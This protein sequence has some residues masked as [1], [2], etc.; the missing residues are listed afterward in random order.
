[1]LHAV[2]QL[3]V[4]LQDANAFAGLVQ[5]SGELGS[6]EFSIARSTDLLG[7]LVEDDAIHSAQSR[8]LALT[9]RQPHNAFLDSAQFRESSAGQCEAVLQMNKGR[10]GELC[11]IC[12]RDTHALKFIGKHRSIWTRD[13]PQSFNQYEAM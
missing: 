13:S 4:A 1:M 2:Q 10:V 6:H 9:L 8:G 7:V 12:Q 5:A 3:K 11:V